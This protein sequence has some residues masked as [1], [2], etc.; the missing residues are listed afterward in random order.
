MS[1]NRDTF[2]EPLRIIISTWSY[3]KCMKILNQSNR[4]C[5][6]Q[7]ERKW[8]RINCGFKKSISANH[9]NKSRFSFEL[10]K[11]FEL[12]I[13]N[14]ATNVDDEIQFRVDVEIYFRINGSTFELEHCELNLHQREA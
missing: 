13:K 5:W 1:L 6:A 3:W 7:R 11:F 10:Q 9:C 14:T 2:G 4:N 12:A 8:W